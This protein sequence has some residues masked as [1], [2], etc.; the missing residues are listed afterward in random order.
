M[1]DAPIAAGLRDRLA[2]AGER[3][4]AQRHLLAVRDGVIAAL[5]LILI[6]STF[7]LLAQPPSARLQAWLAPYAPALL[8]PYRMLGGLVA[9]Y[10]CFGTAR[11]L[12]RSYDLDEL[13]VSLIAL[14]S[15]L[16]AVGV[17]PLEGGGWGIAAER[18]GAAGLFGALAIALASVELQRFFV[19]RRWTVRLPPSVPD[20]IGKSFVSI[21]PGFASIIAIWLLVH[22]VGADLVGLLAQLVRP[23]IGASDSLPG[24]L[25]LVLTDGVMWLFG[26][27]PMAAMAAVKPIWLSMLAENMAAAAAGEAVPH[28]ATREMFLWFVWQGGSGGTL[29]AALLLLRA[30]SASLR[31]V[32]KLG[33]V[34]SLFNVNEPILFGLPVVMN[35][36]FV[37]P[38][39]IAPLITATTAFTAM[40][41]G[42]VAR[43]RLEV[44]WTL[45]APLGAFL[46]TG[47]DPAAVVLQ[48]FNL[49]VA[50]A[51]WWPFV[52]AYDQALVAREAAETGDAEV[53]AEGPTLQ[54]G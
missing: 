4:A 9:L 27:H 3:M 21:V 37:V 48:L 29:A 41:V 32:G 5:P 12:A 23:L 42:W 7:L 36:R 26:V 2:Y 30:R 18:L 15:F 35:P 40:S 51:I 46:S 34:P 44:L 38:F 50:A 43:P 19:R 22:V 1:I 13:G 31:V 45:P 24:A 6:G 47:G 10:A 16:L 25:F 39:L 17:A 14:A 28:V 33:I 54:A 8:A 20:A 53:E 49:G 52:R 11:S